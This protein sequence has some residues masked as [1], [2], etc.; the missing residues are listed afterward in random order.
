MHRSAAPAISEALVVGGYP[1]TIARTKP[2][3]RGR[4]F[5]EYVAMTLE[6]DVRDL[7]VTRSSSASSPHSSASPP[8]A[9]QGCF[10]LPGISRDADMSR[11]TV[12]RYLTLLEQLFLLIRA[13]AWSRNIG[14]RLIK[15]PKVWIPD[16][17][18]A[19][20]LL[21]YGQVRFDED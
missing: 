8:H 1:E 3:G 14:Q 6:R 2:G 19:C 20:H 18:L 13:R 5:E 4:W 11:P 16:T 21:G 9:S 12:Q 7:T 17:G 15:A 10:F